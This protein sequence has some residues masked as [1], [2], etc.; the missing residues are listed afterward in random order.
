VGFV[1]GN[2]GA[3]TGANGGSATGGWT[4]YPYTQGVGGGG[5]TGVNFS[6]GSISA[7]ALA[8]FGSQGYHNLVIAPGGGAG[9]N[10]DGGA[11]RRSITPFFNSGGAGGG[12]LDAGQAGH[13]GN[14][15]YGCGGGGGG[16][17]T[18]GG[19]GG[20][21]GPGLVIIGWV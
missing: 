19:R 15:G 18:T 9:T 14:G 21:G 1:G 20:N 13:G 8:D 2:G 5:S 17:G 10:V 6:G 12:T 11:G 16:A 4:T 7:V 3:H